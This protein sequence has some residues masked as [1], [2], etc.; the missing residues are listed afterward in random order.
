MK[1]FRPAILVAFAATIGSAAGAS[2]I[3]FFGPFEGEPQ[4]CGPYSGYE[5]PLDPGAISSAYGSDEEFSGVLTA[6]SATFAGA[7]AALPEGLLT[8]L[9]WWGLSL[10]PNSFDTCDADD[11]TAFRFAFFEDAAG[12]P[13]TAVGPVVVEV[14]AFIDSGITVTGLALFE[15]SVKF[16]PPVDNTSGAIHWVALHRLFGNNTPTGAGCAFYWVDEDLPGTYDD[17][18]AWVEVQPLESDLAFCVGVQ[19]VPVELL[20][21]TVE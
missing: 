7:V 10:V 18:A 11:D 4:D 15:Y 6:D 13:G 16:E 8:G 21:A 20:E 19:Q 3:A 14:P 12:Q 5:Q 1:R 9:R 17:Q 2:R